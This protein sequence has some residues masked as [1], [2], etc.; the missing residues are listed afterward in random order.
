[1]KIVLASR[2]QGKLSEYR[3][4]FDRLGADVVSLDQAGVDPAIEL[5]EDGDTF[6]ANALSKTAA[7]QR[8]VGGWVMGDDSGLVV[9]ALGGAPGVYSARYAGHPGKGRLRDLANCKKLLAELE[10][11]PDDRRAARFVCVIVLLGPEGQRFSARGECEGRIIRARRGESG[12]GYDPVFLPRGKQRTMAELSMA[13]KN[14]ISHRGHALRKLG[15]I[16]TAE[17]KGGLTP[18]IP[19]NGS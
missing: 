8:L 2:N 12:F 16:L 9:D 10:Y 17:K 14:E 3:R 18:P 7:L 19:E 5:P 13:E 15:E 6:E 1:M 11:T 4:M